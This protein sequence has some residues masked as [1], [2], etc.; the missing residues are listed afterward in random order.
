ML[1]ILS[2]GGQIQGPSLERNHWEGGQIPGLFEIDRIN[3]GANQL[4]FV[5]VPQKD[6]IQTALELLHPE[7]AEYAGSPG[8]PSKILSPSVRDRGWIVEVEPHPQTPR[9]LS[10]GLHSQKAHLIREM[11]ACLCRRRRYPIH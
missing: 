10:S 1:E 11:Q 7:P 4:H 2:P 6:V 8:Q 9:H 3:A 5:R